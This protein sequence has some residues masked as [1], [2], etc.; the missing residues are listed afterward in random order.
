MKV[1]QIRNFAN[2]DKANMYV[3]TRALFV[4]KK[5]IIASMYLHIFE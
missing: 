3:Q 1:Y 2:S 4:C 5:A